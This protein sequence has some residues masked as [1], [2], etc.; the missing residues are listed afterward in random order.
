MGKFE[1]FCIGVVIACILL[2][3]LSLIGCACTATRGILNE[4]G[5]EIPQ[6]YIRMDRGM[7]V[8]FEKVKAE[9]EP[10]IKL[11]DLPPIKLEQ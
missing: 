1:K 8:E 11:P 7:K 3:C 4:Q 5:E 2:I 6:E 9:A 10:L